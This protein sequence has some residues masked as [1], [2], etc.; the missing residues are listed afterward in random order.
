MSNNLETSSLAGVVTLRLNRPEKGNA[1]SASLV[2]ELTHAV[3]HALAD[4][5]THCLVFEGAGKHFCTG[6][7]LSDLAQQSDGDLLLR[8]VQIEQLLGLIWNARCRTVAVAKGRTWGAGADLVAACERRIA[9]EG[10]TFKFPGAGFGLVLGSRRLA[11][12]VGRDHARRWIET[13]ATISALEAQT[14]GLIGRL[15]DDDQSLQKVL[16]SATQPTHLSG[17]TAAAI[18][19]ATA[20]ATGDRI[21]ESGHDLDA[22][23]SALVR[24]ATVPGLKQRIEAYLAALRA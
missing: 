13:D 20:A 12:R 16:H 4:P 18:R 8:F 11:V 7:D 23:L 3:S 6:F 19:V 9:L 10:T 15:I 5:G 14:F 1:L 2:I 17:R 21:P 24:S 22:D